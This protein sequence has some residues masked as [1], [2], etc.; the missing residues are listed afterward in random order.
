LQAA[1]LPG[2][3]YHVI[4][5]VNSLK[6]YEVYAPNYE[7][8]SK[9]ALIRYPHGGTF[10]I[11]ILTVNNKHAAAR[12]LL[13]TDIVDAIGINSK[14]A[15]RLSG[16][17]FDGDTV[18]CIPTH[19]SQGKVKIKNKD[20]LRDLEGFDPKTTYAERPGMKYM[21]DP[22]TGKD[23]T[24]MEMGKISNLITDMTL[25]G[26]SDK[27]LARAVRHSMVVID[28]GKHK[29]DYTKSAV[30]HG[31]EALKAKYQP[32]FDEDGNPTGK[33]GGA[34]TIL[35]KAKGDYTVDRRQG[36]AKVNVKGTKDY[37][38]TR[39]EGALL[40]KTADDL[41][42]PDRNYN[43]ST[44]IVTLR[45]TEGKKITYQ[46]DDAESHSKYDP[47][48]RVDKKTGEVTYTDKSGK[49]TY[50]LN[51]RTQG[52]TQMAETDDA[53]TLMSKARHPME[54]VYADYANSMKALANKARL[55][56]VATPTA[57]YSATAKKTYQQEVNELM[58]ALNT[59]EINTPR[60][61]AAQRKAAADIASKKKADST[62]SKGDIKK[63]ATQAV[64]KYRD[65]VGSVS[66]NDRSI[67][68][69]DR[70]W[71]AIMAGAIT[72]NTLKRILKNTDVDSLRERATPRSN[73]NALNPA[74][75]NRIKQLSASNYTLQQ[76]AE[77]MNL[78]PSTVSKYL[79]GEN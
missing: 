13:G 64:T 9:I 61:R 67:K 38:P 77:K 36:T 19:D 49:I 54:I 46:I 2:Q 7:N 42:Y 22:V 53:Y 15:E 75:V 70:T 39:P 12:K 31:I 35:S 1:A 25:A 48:K 47:V 17:D 4:I 56:M 8:G 24:Q 34:S 72:D 52:S 69:N 6:D 65:E 66:R 59:A 74:K 79:K 18:M 29:L 60:E 21:K 55:E 78:S 68:I 32:K 76:I 27:E 26:A 37:D 50:R 40:Y 43:K 51:K 73:T 5:P 16:A 63:L 30:D 45:T 11:P 14:N 33:G 62:L 3:K 71:E 23:S 57:K 44:K 10:E 41:Y 28:A 20:P 58:S